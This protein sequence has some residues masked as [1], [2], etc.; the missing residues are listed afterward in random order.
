MCS[1]S[2]VRP[3]KPLLLPTIFN[4]LP[5]NDLRIFVYLDRSLFASTFPSVLPYTLARTTTTEKDESEGYTRHVEYAVPAASTAFHVALALSMILRNTSLRNQ[6]LLHRGHSVSVGKNYGGVLTR[7][8]VMGALEGLSPVGDPCINA[9]TC[10]YT[11]QRRSVLHPSP[12]TNVGVF[13][14]AGGGNTEYERAG[15]FE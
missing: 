5:A 14:L 12:G 2:Q 13:S 7:R 8:F 1:I 3:F 4:E 10:E 15:G 6:H 11:P 9:T